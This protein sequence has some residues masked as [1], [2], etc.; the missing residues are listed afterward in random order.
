MANNG[1]TKKSVSAAERRSLSFKLKKG[2]YSYTEIAS[3][4]GISKSQ[5][6]KDVRRVLAENAPANEDVEDFR[7]LL[8]ERYSDMLKKIIFGMESGS[9]EHIDRAIKINEQ[10]AKLK[11]LY[12]TDEININT[13]KSQV[14]II[15]GKEIEF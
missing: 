1:N 8:I 2:G 5:A 12:K 14:F 7:N 9:L 10:I 15:G 3:H 11:Q 4:L 13:N 6:F